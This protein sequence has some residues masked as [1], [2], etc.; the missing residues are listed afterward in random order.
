MDN[1]FNPSNGFTEANGFGSNFRSGGGSSATG[2]AIASDVAAG[3]TFSNASGSAVGT[4]IKNATVTDTAVQPPQAYADCTMTSL[5]HGISLNSVIDWSNKGITSM[6]AA[7]DGFLYD[8]TEA[9]V[10]AHNNALK[11]DVSGNA[12]TNTQEIIDMLATEGSHNGILYINGGTSAPPAAIVF[13]LDLTGV[14]LDASDHTFGATRVDSIGAFLVQILHSLELSDS[15]FNQIDQNNPIL[16][17]GSS[18]SP[19]LAQVIAKLVSL[20]AGNIVDNGD[21]T[22]TVTAGG[23]F[24]PVSLNDTDSGITGTMV[25]DNAALRDLRNVDNWQ[26]STN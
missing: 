10:G 17:I 8:L 14:S 5:V 3:K 24:V 2:N 7:D 22:I 11:L 12:I 23:G 6:D 4:S 25:T 15:T 18:D 20:G 1:G 13:T 9:Y 16:V 26:I 19:N 21:G